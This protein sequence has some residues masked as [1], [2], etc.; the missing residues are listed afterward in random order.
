MDVAPGAKYPRADPSRPVTAILCCLDLRFGFELKT[1]QV[2]VRNKNIFEM[3][4]AAELL[5]RFHRKLIGPVVYKLTYF[6]Y[7]EGRG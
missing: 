5:F 2:S 3:L 6:S 1:T 7:L 4:C